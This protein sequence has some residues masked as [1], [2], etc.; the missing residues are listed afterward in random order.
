M[1]EKISNL[2]VNFEKIKLLGNDLSK[3]TKRKIEA[4]ITAVTMLFSGGCGPIEEETTPAYQ[5]NEQV[6]ETQIEETNKTI[7]EIIEE[8]E[9]ISSIENKTEESKL[10]E[11]KSE[12][13]TIIEESNIENISE[14]EIPTE[15]ETSKT[16]VTIE[17]DNNKP[18]VTEV[19]NKEE[20]PVTKKTTVTIEKTQVTTI[21]TEKPKE[22]TKKTTVTIEKD[23]NPTTSATKPTE[24]AVTMPPETEPP[25]T[26]TTTPITE[27]PVT[28][29][30]V[31]EPPVT[32][33][34]WRDPSDYRLEEI[35]YDPIAF[36]IFADSLKKDLLNGCGVPTE[37][38]TVWGA[39]EAQC[40]L[41]ILNHG[42]I[43]DDVLES[44]LGIHTAEDITN[45]TKFIYKICY[46]Q[47][48]CGTDVDFEKYTLDPSIG[49]FLNSID[50]AYRNG[51]INEVLY[52]I[53]MDANI[54]EQYLY[55]PS[56]LPVL[57]SY[58]RN[59]TQIN[60]DNVDYFCMDAYI[61]NLCNT[62]LGYSYTR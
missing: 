49:Q 6:I 23:K 37:Y 32:E 5:V 35:A 36:A 1:K 27:P 11:S 7:E 42:K 53:F 13:N 26:T 2:K 48:L 62:V 24:P 43:N 8:S 58:D 61:D 57:Y 10:E 47:E 59:C 14:S 22:T 38:G 50:D 19:E 51:T 31:T 21:E 9:I 15:K 18:E 28:E 52:N 16:T 56:I 34:V 20:A 44:N 30:I 39:T 29:P 4:T 45:C 41:A 54:L 33:P 46:A 12:N 60:S 55:N 25:V 40:I 17:K 3:T